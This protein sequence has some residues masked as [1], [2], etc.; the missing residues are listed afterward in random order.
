MVCKERKCETVIGI[1]VGGYNL[2]VGQKK[3][4]CETFIKNGMGVVIPWCAEERNVKQS[5][6]SVW[7]LQLGC[8][9]KEGKV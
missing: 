6:E 4:K 8:G 1:S 3:G 7:G 9:P 2:S 5:R